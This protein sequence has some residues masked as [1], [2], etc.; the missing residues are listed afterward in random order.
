[1]RKQDG[2]RQRKQ[3]EVIMFTRTK[4]KEFI[5][6]IT[7]L[8]VQISDLK[9][10]IND[11]QNEN[12]KLHRIL[13]HYIPGEITGSPSCARYGP[14]GIEKYLNLYVYKGGKE[15]VFHG[16]MISDPEIFQGEKD[17]IVYISDKATKK[18]YVLDLFQESFIELGKDDSNEV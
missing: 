7:K 5:G 4:I 12:E 14:F 17:N 13:E 18:R 3:R 1:M 6:Q 11:L 2:V 16:I 8:S 15:Y 9:K 10:E